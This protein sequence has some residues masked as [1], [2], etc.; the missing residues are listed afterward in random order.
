VEE[1]LDGPGDEVSL[2]GQIQPDPV[3]AVRVVVVEQQVAGELVDLGDAELAGAGGG[4]AVQKQPAEDEVG[5]RAAD[6]GAA[7]KTGPQIRWSSG[8]AAR[9]AASG[10]S[11]RRIWA[12]RSAGT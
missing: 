5:V 2:A 9:T 11:A 12:V 3:D 8:R 6:V 10:R 1:V 4:F 7:V